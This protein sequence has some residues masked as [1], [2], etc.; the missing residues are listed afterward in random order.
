MVWPSRSAKGVRPFTTAS[1]HSIEPMMPS[2]V[3]ASLGS[4]TSVSFWDGTWV[5]PISRTACSAA[6]SAAAP[7]SSSDGSRP[8]STP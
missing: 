7:R 1:P 5:A 8:A 2:M 3:A 4:S 6:S